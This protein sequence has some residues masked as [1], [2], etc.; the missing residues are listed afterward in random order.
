MLVE[1]NTNYAKWA[2]NYGARRKPFSPE[3]TYT[4]YWSDRVGPVG[5][6]SKENDGL[7]LTIIRGDVAIRDI[8]SVSTER[9]IKIAEAR[10]FHAPVLPVSDLSRIV[11]FVLD[12]PKSVSDAGRV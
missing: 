6:Y 7:T 1:P 5:Q 10:L 8:P 3:D 2:A 4:R 11:E 9:V 12:F